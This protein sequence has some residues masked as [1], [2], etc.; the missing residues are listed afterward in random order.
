MTDILEF[1]LLDVIEEPDG[2]TFGIAD[3]DSVFLDRAE[4]RSLFKFLA[5]VINDWDREWN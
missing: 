5:E 2:V 3:E 1:G 4:V